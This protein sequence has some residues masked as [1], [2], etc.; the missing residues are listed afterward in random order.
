MVDTRRRFFLRAQPAPPAQPRPPGALAEGAFLDACTRCGDCATT[1]PTQ[2]IQ[3]GDGGYPVLDFSRNGCEL[4]GDCQRA[5][6]AGALPGPSALGGWLAELTLAR[7][8]SSRGVECR[9]CGDACEP[10]AL[11]F[12]PGPRGVALPQLEAEACTACGHCVGVCPTQAL[13]VRRCG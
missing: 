3:R 13:S 6:R 8:L 4:C 2:V 9:L 12:Q 7:C 5:C 10:R 1:C 11:R